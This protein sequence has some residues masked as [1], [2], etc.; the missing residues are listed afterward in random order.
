MNNPY[1][2]QAGVQNELREL[3]ACTRE[4]QTAAGGAVAD[5]LSG[6]LAGQYVSVCREELAGAQGARRLEILRGLVRDWS[7]LRHGDHRVSRVQL[8]REK[9][10][11]RRTCTDEAKEKEFRQW[12]ERPDIRKEFFPEARGGITD[13][14]LRKIEEAARIL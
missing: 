6:W 10:D 1:E 8:E 3:S 4:F 14:T 11:L 13:E 2:N 5:A 12:I 7:F 9:L